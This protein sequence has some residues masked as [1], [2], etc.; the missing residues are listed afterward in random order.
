M[1]EMGRGRGGWLV[2]GQMRFEMMN[3]TIISLCTATRILSH[4][5]IHV[6]SLSLCVRLFIGV[7]MRWWPLPPETIRCLPIWSVMQDIFI[8][9]ENIATYRFFFP[10]KPFAVCHVDSSLQMR[11]NVI[12]EPNWITHR[13]F[14]PHNAF[15]LFH[16]SPPL[17]SID[18]CCT[19]P[20]SISPMP[21]LLAIRLPHKPDAPCQFDNCCCSVTAIPMIAIM[22]RSE[23]DDD[24]SVSK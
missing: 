10:H 1:Q 23:N 3:T 5:D 8:S 19:L 15:N 14:F 2:I 9:S 11:M 17:P 24:I 18:R 13:F 7:S 21:P 16:E 12:D 6:T 20:I 4:I 22:T